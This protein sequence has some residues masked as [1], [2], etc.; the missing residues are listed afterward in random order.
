MP[1][2]G[3]ENRTENWRAAHSF[4]PLFEDAALRRRFASLL[5]G[6]PVEAPVSLELFWHGL[7]DYGIRHGWK[8][9]GFTEAYGRPR[10]PRSPPASPSSSPRPRRASTS[11][12]RRLSVNM[13]TTPVT[14]IQ[15]SSS[16][17]MPTA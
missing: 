16:R 17:W 2:L 6:E 12:G 8:R 3:I 7:H 11:R 10:Y 15:A 13:A 5:L 9:P 4:A 14:A 1:I